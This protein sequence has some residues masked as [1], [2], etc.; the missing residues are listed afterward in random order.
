MRKGEAAVVDQAVLLVRPCTPEG[1]L[2]EIGP[3]VPTMEEG[4]TTYM[5]IF[6]EAV[7]VSG[8][9]NMTFCTPAAAADGQEGA[10]G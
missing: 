5:A 9:E 4:P 3:V 1:L 6:W 7:R 8:L 10:A 2:R